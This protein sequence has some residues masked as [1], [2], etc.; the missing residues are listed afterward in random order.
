MAH[1][2]IQGAHHATAGDTVDAQ[3]AQLESRLL[4]QYAHHGK[5]TEATVRDQFQ[6]AVQRFANARIRS[7]LPI[8]IERAV[9]GKLI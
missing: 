9:K 6:H 8:L 5:H 4:I 1:T 7:F 3:L 2:V